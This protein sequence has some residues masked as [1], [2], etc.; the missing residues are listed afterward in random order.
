MSGMILVMLGIIF[1]IANLGIISWSFIFNIF[2]LWPLVLIIVGINFIFRRNYIVRTGS[3]IFLIVAVLGY[4]IIYDHDYGNYS[5]NSN[6]TQAADA[7]IKD[8]EVASS[9]LELKLG[10]TELDLYG[11]NEKYLVD[12]SANDKIHHRVE[13]YKDNKH[14][15]IFVENSSKE[16]FGRRRINHKIDLSLNTEIPWV[17]N[18]KVGA[19]KGRLDFSD[20][21]LTE[22]NIEV[23]AGD[24]DI[25][26]GEL[27]YITSAN[28]NA[29]ASNLKLHIPNDLGVKINSSS[30]LSNT[31][32]SGL[33]WT[34]LGNEYISPN[35]DEAESKIHLDIKMGIG[36]MNVYYA[37]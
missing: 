17:I 2:T 19:I 12:I 37:K 25:Q 5:Y 16:F 34:K 6:Y 9:E 18:A 15:I 35:Y 13:S 11:G 33:G 24:L 26:F 32:L 3:W 36:N 4:S 28:I 7:V 20:I 21:E 29:G 22:L 30:V 14:A 8:E 10:G 1:L 27:A 31:N 23:G